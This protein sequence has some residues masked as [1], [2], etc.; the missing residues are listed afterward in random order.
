M[1][2]EN[3]KVNPFTWLWRYLRESRE[4]MRKVTWPSK[5]DTTRYSIIVIG[6]SV[7]VGAFFAGFDW[8]LNQGLE[9]LIKLTS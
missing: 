3:T 9:A 4:E 5:Q 1:Q 2:T 7:V 6:I 8:I